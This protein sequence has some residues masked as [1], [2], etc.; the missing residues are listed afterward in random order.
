[1]R[2][3]VTREV[4]ARLVREIPDRVSRGASTAQR[5]AKTKKK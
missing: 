4:A 2:I 3:E 1:M 5:A